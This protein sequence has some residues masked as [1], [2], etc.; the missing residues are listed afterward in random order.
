[1][2]TKQTRY[3]KN[4]VHTLRKFIEEMQTEIDLLMRDPSEDAEIKIKVCRGKIPARRDAI[5]YA[6]G[7]FMRNFVNNDF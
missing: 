3:Q 1:M 4:R 6:H 2:K 5:N 7:F